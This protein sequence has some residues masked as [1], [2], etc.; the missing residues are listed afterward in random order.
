MTRDGVTRDDAIAICNEAKQ[1]MADCNYDPE[2]C[3]DIMQDSLG[4]E[5]DY[6]FSLLL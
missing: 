5:L 3:E 6:I 1:Q 2:E 4:L